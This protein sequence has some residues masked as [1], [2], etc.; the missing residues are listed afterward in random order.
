MPTAHLGPQ[1]T[2]ADAGGENIRGVARAAAAAPGV[3]RN[4]AAM[5]LNQ[6]AEGEGA[7]IAKS[8]QKQL[9]ADD[10]Y[11]A[12]ESF[13]KNLREKA[14][15]VYEAAYKAGRQ[16][17]S[18]KLNSLLE[19][20]IGKRAMREAA[21]LAGIE[22]RRVSQV[23]PQLTSQANAAIALGKT[24]RKDIPKGGIGRGIT[25]EAIDDLKRGLDSLIERQTN[26]LTGRL[27]K[28]GFA[29]AAYKRELLREVDRL[30]PAYAKARKIYSGD[31]EILQALRDGRNAV[32]LDPEVV[33]KQIGG[34]SGAAKEAYRAGAARAL[35]DIVDKTPD[36]TSAARRIFAS[37]RNRARWR[38]IFPDQDSFRQFSRV[39]MAEAQF[40]KTRNFV[41]GG[42]PTQPRQADR[43]DLLTNLAGSAG[44]GMGTQ[45]PGTHARVA[46]QLG[47]KAAQSVFGTDFGKVERELTRMLFNRNPAMNLG[48]LENLSR[49][50][51]A[52]GISNEQA[53]KIG[54]ALLSVVGQQEGK[55][56]GQSQRP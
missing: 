29:I 48:T 21:K 32:K 7:R 25:T 12:E 15:P 43:Q 2:I 33:R 42:S 10:F 23:D 16:L 45:I 28:T 47:R 14:K 40:T 4:R 24:A 13:L 5:V 37:S 54:R 36:T 38:E 41:T 56:A 3:A 49:I 26:E 1:G 39:M 34:L 53:A 8:V 22:G 51:A 46:S 35:K 30:N 18:K 31:A 9:S 27:N 19:R 44:A 11:A 52:K 50:E 17:E 20:S 55:M 6:R